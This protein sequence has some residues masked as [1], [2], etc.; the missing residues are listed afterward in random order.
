MK[1][2]LAE[3]QIGV[4]SDGLVPTLAN[5]S[6]CYPDI[7]DWY[8]SVLSGESI[9]SALMSSCIDV[10]L[11][12]ALFLGITTGQLDLILEDL[13]EGI[14]VKSVI[15]KYSDIDQTHFC[16]ECLKRE[17]DLIKKRAEVEGA[18]LLYLSFCENYFITQRYLGHSVT[19][20]K[21]NG[22]KLM[23]N[24]LKDYFIAH[25]TVELNDGMSL[26]VIF[27]VENN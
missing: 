21:V 9:A 16:N 5:L 26:E 27:S 13:I 3:L 1:G 8:Q 17:I 25:N 6:E 10:K 4:L 24:A 7:K 12:G 14:D 18:K 11:K 20:V 19:D 23:F 2:I 22:H 15:V